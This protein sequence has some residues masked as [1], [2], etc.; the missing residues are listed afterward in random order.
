MESKA[1]ARVIAA[2]Y[3]EKDLTMEHKAYE[4]DWDGFSKE[5]KP[6]M[7][8]ALSSG[9]CFKILRFIE[10]HKEK[11]TDPYEGEPLLENWSEDLAFESL[12]NIL[13]Y[14]LTKYYSVSN[15]LG[16]GYE[17]LVL[18]DDLDEKESISLL[19]ESVYEFNPGCYGSYFQPESVLK[20][21]IETLSNVNEPQIVSFVERLSALSKGL[22]VTF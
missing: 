14:A 3:G 9:E 1:F 8:E 13:D 21:S 18:S 15:D 22:Y 5:L 2:L 7:L 19:G 20:T 6:L 4:F 10:K 17:W 12:Q 11:V 16:L